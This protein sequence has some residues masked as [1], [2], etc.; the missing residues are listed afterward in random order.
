LL[1]N[2]IGDYLLPVVE[3]HIDPSQCGG[4]KGTSVSHY[5]IRVLDFIHSALDRKDPHA[6]LLSTEDLSKAFNRGSHN[7]VIEDLHAMGVPGWLLALICSYLAGRTLVLNYQGAA[8]EPRSYR[9][10]GPIST[11]SLR[12]PYRTISDS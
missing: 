4:L 5:L 1:E 11:S 7:L 9:G 2:I 8:A 10:P 3:P 12:R 6:V